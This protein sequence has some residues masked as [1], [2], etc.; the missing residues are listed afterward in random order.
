MPKK[1]T[2]RKAPPEAYAHASADR[3]NLP[4][5]E[6]AP[7][8]TDADR[9]PRR[10]EPPIRDDRAGEPRLSWDRGDDPNALEVESHPLYIHEKIHPAAFVRSLT[11]APADR[12]ETR[13]LFGAAYNDLPENAAYEWYEH[14]GNWQNRLIRGDSRRIMASLADRDRLAGRVQMV[15]YDPPYGI[16]FNSNFQP[17]V[18]KRDAG[19]TGKAVPSDVGIVRAFRDAYENGIHSYLDNI[20]RN[21]ILAR[22]L[23]HDSGSLFVQISGVNV[24]RLAVLL[25]EVFGAENH[26][27]MI[28]FVKSGGS[29][30]K[31]LPQVADYLLWYAKEKATLKFR[32]LF[33]AMSRREKISYRPSYTMVELADGSVRKLTPDEIA[34]P[35]ESLP[36]GARVFNLARLTSQGHSTTGRSEPFR[37]KGEEH[38]CPPARQWSVGH[39]GLTNMARQGR[40][41]RAKGGELSWKWYEDEIPGRRLHNVWSAQMSPSDLHYVV[42]TAELVVERC[43]LMATDPGDLV[44]DI[45][46]GSGTTAFVAEKWGR[47]WITTDAAAVPIALARQRLAVGAFP[48]HL[49]Q[50]S[51]EGA[52]K[53]RELCGTGEADSQTRRLAD[54]QTRRLVG[55]RASRRMPAIPRRASCT[56]AF[57]MSAPPSSRTTKF[58]TSRPWWIARARRKASCGFPPR[59][60]WRASRR[61]GTFPLTRTASARSSTT[62]TSP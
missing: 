58:A 59:S 50:D 33:E 32:Q 49:L 30:S 37:W 18:N 36:E 56:S 41:T 44:L 5:E 35:D 17:S 1:K 13:K 29:S 28:P 38:L 27:A 2:T 16:K 3:L 54:S 20:R 43:L 51:P 8:M 24:H 31:T 12:R 11:T 57:P 23:L 60:P 4:T 52:L 42:E 26:V 19:T 39:E 10:Y 22:T 7:Y 47:R 9:A 53:E 21:A 45:T 55:R 48:Y 61:G 34:D 40:L 6:T 46:C 15:Y 62:P 14:R 25:D